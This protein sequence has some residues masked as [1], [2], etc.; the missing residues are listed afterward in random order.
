[1]LNIFQPVDAR[2]RRERNLLR[3]QLHVELI[4]ISSLTLERLKEKQS[5]LLLRLYTMEHEQ[6]DVDVPW[7]SIFTSV[8]FFTLIAAHCG[9]TWG[10]YTLLTEVSTYL[11]SALNLD[12]KSNAS[13]S[14]LP[15]FVTWIL[16]LVLS[17]MAD[18]L[19][20]NTLT[21]QILDDHHRRP[22]EKRPQYCPG[23]R[24]ND[25]PVPINNITYQE[26]S[27]KM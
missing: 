2:T 12:M 27:I 21:R 22:F 14:A 7:R 16:C 5:I 26:N 25:S 23:T 1:M 3:Q 17:P 19:I 15:H 13:L 4:W 6:R 20:L 18:L 8:P 10:F 9:F 11:N 24:M